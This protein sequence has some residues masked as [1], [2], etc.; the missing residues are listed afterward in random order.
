MPTHLEFLA[1]SAFRPRTKPSSAPRSQTNKNAWRL[2]HNVEVIESVSKSLSYNIRDDKTL[3]DNSI[4]YVYPAQ[5]A[6]NL[7]TQ[8]E[9]HDPASIDRHRCIPSRAA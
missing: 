2:I 1:M 7:T 9:A 5:P 4:L 8:E 6:K 3:T